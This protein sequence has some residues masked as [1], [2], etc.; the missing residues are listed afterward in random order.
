MIE[1]Q[2]HPHVFVGSGHA[3][4][5]HDETQR[6]IVERGISMQQS[7]NT[8]SAVEFLKSRDVGAKVIA[9]VLLEPERRRSNDM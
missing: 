2:L 7:S 9:R 8:M 3:E 4:A 6:S 5:R 1:P